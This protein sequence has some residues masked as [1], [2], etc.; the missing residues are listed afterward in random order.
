VPPE[1]VAV[2]RVEAS[3]LVWVPA[4]ARYVVV[5]DETGKD[6]SHRPWLFTMS[7]RGV[8]DP[9]PMTVADVSELDDIESITA[10]ETGTLWIASSQSLSE[11]GNRPH[12]RQILARL[13]PDGAAYKVDRKVHLFELLAANP[14]LVRQLGVTNLDSL[15]I[16]GMA[17]HGGALY[18]GL[19]APLDAQGRAVIW[20][21]G[22]PDK[23]LAGDLAGAAI[24]LFASVKMTVN[25]NGVP[26]P[27]GIADM[28][29]LSDSTLAMGATASGIAAKH[30]DGVVYYVNI[31]NAETTAL[32]MRTFSD[33][34]PEGVALS[35]DGKLTVLFDRGRETP[36]WTTL[37]LPSSGM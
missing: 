23:L 35:P 34:R 26:A 21:V 33:L 27:A 15:D 13:A 14:E 22:A 16:E 28:V 37:E 9:E 7:P 24:S 20:K 31:S 6:G 4:L 36:M 1:I 17:W 3:G 2:T 32:P 11:R 10:G 12:A 5:S 8:L 19:K 18:L 30:Q 29:F 25:V